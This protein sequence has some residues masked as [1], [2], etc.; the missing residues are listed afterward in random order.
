M[1]CELTGARGVE[2]MMGSGSLANDAVCGQLTLLDAPGLILS[3][4]EF[5]DRLIDHGTRQRLPFE[6]YQIG[7]GE[8]FDLGEVARRLDANPALRWIWAVHCETSTGVLN[9]LTALKHVAARRGLTLALDCISSIGTVPVDL[10]DVYLATC[11]SGKALA[12]YPGLS[13]VFHNHDFAPAPQRL[14]RYSDLGFYSA[15]DGIPFTTSSNLLN[16]LQTALGR[17]VWKDKYRQIEEDGA[18]LRERLREVGLQIVAPDLF[19]SP[20]VISIAL[21]PEID[22]KSV[23]WQLKKAGYLL[24]YNSGYLLK[25]NWIQICLM[26]EWSRSTLEMLPDVLATLC[27]RSRRPNRAGAITESASAQSA[28]QTSPSWPCF[29]PSPVAPLAAGHSDRAQSGQLHRPFCHGGGVDPG[30]K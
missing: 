21:P 18:W 27:A 17:V 24:S 9:D 4:G 12:S 22:S 26:G 20:A 3:N 15:Q 16:A 14:P 7:W 19:A 5:G 11:V 8:P 2:I 23:G 29:A 6:V 10:S 13:M 30:E 25:R 28:V 1:L